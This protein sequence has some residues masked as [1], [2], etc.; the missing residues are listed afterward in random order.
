MRKFRWRLIDCNKC[1]KIYNYINKNSLLP[2][3]RICKKK[4]PDSIKRI[5]LREID[6]FSSL[7]TLKS[8]KFLFVALLGIG[9][10][11]SILGLCVFMCAHSLQSCPTLCDHLDCSLPVSSVHGTVQARILEWAAIPS[12]RGSSWPRDWTCVSYIANKFFTCWAI[13]E[14]HP[15]S[16]LTRC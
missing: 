12:W 1:N 11:L 2:D 6:I 13:K 10:C 4:N 8:I 14:A 3:V 9:N 15:W 7:M 5:S 16:L